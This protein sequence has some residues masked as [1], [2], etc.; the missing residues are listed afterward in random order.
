MPEPLGIQPHGAGV[1]LMGASQSSHL[2][3][4]LGQLEGR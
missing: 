3:K 2:E 4:G 1:L